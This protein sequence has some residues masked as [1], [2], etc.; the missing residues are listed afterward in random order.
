MEVMVGP[1]Y[2]MEVSVP[3]PSCVL[4]RSGVAAAQDKSTCLLLKGNGGEKEDHHETGGEKVGPGYGSDGSSDSLSSIG[5][6]GDS[7]EEEND[8]VA[9]SSKLK[10]STLSLVSLED[11]LPIKRGLSNHYTGRS[12][13]FANL[14]DVSTVKDLGKEENSFNKRRRLF[15][16]NKLSRNNRRSSFYSW[17]NPI[18]MPLLPALEEEE[19]KDHLHPH[20]VQNLSSFKQEAAE[21]EEEEQQ[22]QPIK[23]PPTKT[24][25]GS[26]FKIGCKSQS[27]F[28]LADLQEDQEE[29]ENQW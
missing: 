16:V 22:Q 15:M 28:S 29:E 12:K 10:K 23:N 25:N 8:D 20:Q 26:R 18:S 7:E 17:Q 14:S 4:D 5:D 21:E 3:S 9:S 19:E 24:L 2:S 27:C 6:S 1:T 13:S 11:S